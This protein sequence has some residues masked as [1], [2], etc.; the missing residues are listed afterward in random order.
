MSGWPNY[1]I[2][3]V[4]GYATMSRSFAYLGIPPLKLF[5][6]EVSIAA[7]LV[8]HPRAVF[9]RWLYA[10]GQW[11]PLTGFAAALTVF[12]LYGLV[13]VARGLDNGYRSII[14]LQSLAFQYYP[15]C[16]FIGIWVGLRQAAVLPR[17]IRILAWVNGIY[18]LLF[19]VILNR[20]FMTVPGTSDVPLFGQPIGATTAII[21]LIC[22]ERRLSD[23]WHLLLMNVL[24]M[25]GLLMRAEY[26]GCTLGLLVWGILARRFGRLAILFG[27]LVL[28][29]GLGLVTDFSMEAPSSRGGHI[30]AKGIAG[31]MV[32]PAD[33]DLAAQLTENNA[34]AVSEAGTAEWR[35]RW[36]KAIW[37]TVHEDTESTVFGLGYGYP[38]AGLVGYTQR[39]LR[40]PHSVFFYNLAYGG[41]LGVAIFAALQV[42]MV[43]LMWRAW[44][45]TGNPFGVAL[46]VALFCA[47][48]L[49]NLL[50]TPF[51]AIPFYLLTGLAAA[52]VLA[53]VRSY[54]NPVGAQLLST[55]RG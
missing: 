16:F 35:T 42:A 49:G 44:R 28:L 10:L 47:A 34:E 19:I 22:F 31:R 53:E 26:V 4:V 14:V 48:L 51:G 8:L 9:D 7:F 2:F 13:E 23:V 45:V 54:A 24:V 27:S 12:L 6:G 18:G 50:E 11:N 36:W 30:S 20:F 37:Q 55:A 52:P 46:W 1:I 25:L 43:S 29:L 38:I 15:I 33:P 32:A 3:L 5:I 39:D 17:L 21:G 41:W 40:T